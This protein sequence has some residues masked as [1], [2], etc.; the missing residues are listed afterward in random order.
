MRI[1]LIDIDSLRPDHLA[2]YGYHRQTSQHIDSV[3]ARGVRFTNYYA[4]DTPCLP[5]RTAFFSGLFGLITG[6]INHGGKFSDLPM[7]GD[8]RKFRA[9]FAENSLGRVLT[10]AGFHTASISSFPQRH[11][12]YQ[13]WQGFSETHDPGKGG[14]DLADDVQPHVERWLNQNGQHDNWFLHV[15]YWDPHT[16]YDV[17]FDYG[18]PF[19]D[20][21]ID[22]W[23]TQEIIDAQVASYGP[24]SA[25]ELPGYTPK[26]YGNWLRG[27]TSVKDLADAKAHIDAYDTGIHYVDAFIGRILTQLDTLGIADETAIIITADHGENHGELN[28]WGDHQTADQITNRIPLI[29][30]WPG[31]TDQVAGTSDDGFHYHIDFTATL[32]EL[33]GAAQPEQWSGESFRAALSGGQAGRDYLVLGHGA[34]SCQRSVRWDNW[35]LIRTYHT[36][37]K[38]F[39]AYMLFDIANDPHEMTNLADARPDVVGQGLQRIDTWLTEQMPNAWRGDPI[40]GVVREGGGLH[41]NTNNPQWHTYLQRLRDTGRGQHAD[42]LAENGGKPR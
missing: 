11:S 16:P 35:L 40:W 7:Q 19:A 29:I 42:W 32:A 38:A 8:S 20:E 3:A 5:S 24:H 2:C 15:N 37:L 36:G 6:V 41:A 4:T 34:W 30:H 12:A 31:I 39:P 26:F 10:R 21:S 27:V 9:E 33:V 1:L 25:S 18:D 23:L 14:A 13:I 17:P 22:G 28:V